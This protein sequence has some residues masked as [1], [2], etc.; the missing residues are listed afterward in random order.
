MGSCVSDIGYTGAG[1]LQSKSIVVKATVDSAIQVAIALWERNSS[2]SI[3]N[4]Q[5]ELADRQTKLAENIHEHAKQF[6][7]AEAALVAD[8]F[9]VGK[10]TT[11]YHGLANGWAAMADVEISAG[12]ADW[13]RQ[14]AERCTAVSQCDDAR[15]QRNGQV[16]RADLMSYAARQDENR[17]QIINDRRYARQYAVLGLGKGQLRDLLSYQAIGN[18]IGTNASEMLISTV[19][20]ALTTYGF[21]SNRIEVQ[22][23]GNGARGMLGAPQAVAPMGVKPQ[24]TMEAAPAQVRIAPVAPELLKAPSV[25]KPFGKSNEWSDLSSYLR[26]MEDRSGRY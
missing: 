14:M 5:D 17:T 18:S 11:Q 15:W 25:P 9:G 20:S 6:W 22:R 26:K 24:L 21:Y 19:N 13:Q 2:E 3:A 16:V 1:L 23:W 4:M 8:V 12:R 10:V 7:P